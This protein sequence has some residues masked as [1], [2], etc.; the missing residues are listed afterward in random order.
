MITRETR[1]MFNSKPRVLQASGL[2]VLKYIPPIAGQ[3][4]MVQVGTKSVNGTYSWGGKYECQGREHART[5]ALQMNAE[6]FNFHIV[7]SVK[8]Y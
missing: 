5:I 2:L 3:L 7:D 6:P 4:P 1:P 8:R